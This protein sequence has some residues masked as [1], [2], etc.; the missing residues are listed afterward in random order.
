M[1]LGRTGG[2]DSDGSVVA[3]NTPPLVLRRAR[4]ADG[5]RSDVQIA[6]GRIVAI[7]PAGLACLEPGAVEV[8]LDD[9]LL[10]GA[11]AE[12][13]AHLDKAYTAD[14]V[15]NPAGDLSGAVGAWR[16][17]RAQQTVDVIAARARAAALAA[18]AQGVTAIRTH[19][20]VGPGVE[21][22]AVEALVAVR[23]ELRE[24]LDLQIVV[25]SYPLTGD[26][27]VSGPAR[28]RLRA[29]LAMGADLVGG[30]P[31][32]EPEPV[33]AIGIALDIAQ[34]A[35]CGVDLHM[36]EHLRDSV[37]VRELARLKRAG[38]VHQAT[39]SHCSSLGMC[40]ADLQQDVA[41]ELA[42]ADVGV[43]TCPAT[44]LFLQSR[45]QVAAPPRGLTAVRALLDAGA[46][47]AGGGDNVQDPF[48]PL[49]NSD[50]LETAQLLV[51]AGHVSPTEACSAVSGSARALMGLAPAD[52]VV[53]AIADLVAVRAGS[54]R[55]AVAERSADRIVI[56]AGRIVSRTSLVHEAAW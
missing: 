11:F 37:D 55:E 28:A 1:G 47:V 2:P 35:G 24:L 33:E 17:Y 49:G 31:H 26:P 51:L 50:P 53:G 27:D 12:P 15:E 32:G 44:N 45:D 20:D 34:A 14:L 56:R 43:V 8:D 22:K 4:L 42:A 46:R 18:L 21:L 36:D 38:F 13:H 25:M 29:A 54:V 30:T 16:G 40:P 19:V 23:E 39:A 6:N 48:N 41:E 52:V 10:L 3:V 5:R 9:R 7:E